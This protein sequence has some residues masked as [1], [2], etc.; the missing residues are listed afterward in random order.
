MKKSYHKFA[1]CFMILSI[2]GLG[3]AIY[4]IKNF[5]ESPKTLGSIE[6]TNFNL[7]KLKRKVKKRADSE[8]K[9]KRK[10]LKKKMAQ[11]KPVLNTMLSGSSFGMDFDSFDS[12]SLDKDLLDSDDNVVMDENSVDS[13]PTLLSQESV[14]FPEKALEENIDRGKVEL[15]ILID[16]FGKVDQVEIIE[17]RPEGYFEDSAIQMVQRWEFDPATYRGKSVAIWAKQVVKFG[18]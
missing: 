10:K 8:V 15:R 13:K 14:D 2:L 11:L 18:E 12:V 5:L 3:S 16:K 7:S 1:L 4:L 17:A 9:K 6:E